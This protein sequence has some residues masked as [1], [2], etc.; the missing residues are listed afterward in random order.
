MGLIL[1]RCRAE[2]REKKRVLGVLALVVGLGG[3]VALSAFAGARRADTAMGQFVAYSLPDDGGFFSQNTTLAGQPTNAHTLT[4][5]AQRVVD[6]PQVAAYFRAPYLFVT[7]D[8]SGRTL[9]RLSVIGNSD[10][11]LFRSVD[12]PLVLAGHLPNPSHPLEVSINEFA[13]DQEHLHVGSHLRLYAYSAA[14][15]ANEALTAPTAHLPAP[16]GPSFRVRVTA[17]VRSVEDVNAVLPLVANLD[18]SYEGQGDVFTSPAFV[19]LLAAKLGIPVNQ[20]PDIGLVAVR[21]HPGATWS[22]FARAA[23]YLGGDPI[24]VSKGN[25]Y[26]IPQAASSAQRG[27]HLEVVALLLFGV[28]ALLVML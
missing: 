9:G 26:S 27:I 16:A 17:I 4:P 22:S 8:K 28:L 12:R 23:R 1:L 19:P 24:F 11:A 7:D 14:Q 21:L 13:A 25:V 10:A 2:V 15:A 3:G 18:V 20:I 5:V 6:L